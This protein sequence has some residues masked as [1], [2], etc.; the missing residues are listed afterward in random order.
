M[1]ILEMLP[2]SNSNKYIRR[3]ARGFKGNMTMKRVHGQNKKQ[4]TKR[5]ETEL[6]QHFE[7]ISVF[8]AGR[9]VGEEE[10]LYA[11]ERKYEGLVDIRWTRIP[12]HLLRLSRYQ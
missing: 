10:S 4:Q 6:V 3:M 1:R 11:R 5:T 12:S 2:L 9:E 8:G 7:N